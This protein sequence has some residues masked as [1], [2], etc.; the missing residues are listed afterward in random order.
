[1]HMCMQIHTCVCTHTHSPRK[2]C[3]L[4]K[5]SGMGSSAN[6]K[7]FY[8]TTLLQTNIPEQFTV[9]SPPYL[10]WPSVKPNLQA[11][12]VVMKYANDFQTLSPLHPA[13]ML[14]E[15]KAQWRFRHA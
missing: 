3:S 7:N 8:I 15:K 6:T 10:Q 2:T 1:M 4:A 14:S 13:R 12:H 9:P 5:R 11:C